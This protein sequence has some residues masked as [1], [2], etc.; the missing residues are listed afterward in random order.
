MF[1]LA[2]YNIFM[3]GMVSFFLSCSF[4]ALQFTLKYMLEAV[5]EDDETFT[6]DAYTGR[7]ISFTVTLLLCPFVPV[8]INKIGPRPSVIIAITCHLLYGLQFL[9]IRNWL[10][11]VGSMVVGM[12][13]TTMWIAQGRFIAQNSTETTIGRN[14]SIF[15]ILANVHGFIRFAYFYF[16][17]PE[18]MGKKERT[19]FYVIFNLCYVVALVVSLFLLKAKYNKPVKEPLLKSLLK[20][21]TLLVRRDMLLLM[22]SVL[23]INVFATWVQFRLNGIIFTEGMTEEQAPMKRFAEIGSISLA[24]T[25]FTGLIL[26][27]FD[28]KIMVLTRGH[29]Y[30]IVLIGFFLHV[31]QMVM[32]FINLPD[33]S[34]LGKTSEEG[35]IKPNYILALIATAVGGLSGPS[36]FSRKEALLLILCQDDI[37]HGHALNRV[38]L[39]L[40][41]V[42]P[43]TLIHWIGFYWMTCITLFTG[44]I[45][46]VSFYACERIYIYKYSSDEEK[47]NERENIE[48]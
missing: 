43:N 21:F 17:F 26:S 39:S 24:C 1:H 22:P 3:I 12:G 23:Y 42:I 29:H 45:S 27:L 31:L 8:M 9:L 25:V 44:L 30:P 20:L 19:E 13:I 14:A 4:Q 10:Y 33:D 5:S 34:P 47:E 36:I 32:D 15:N 7:V 28:K 2:I 11:I 16:Q 41:V 40:G 48:E 18:E 35:I 37:A 6:I 46:V 38:Y